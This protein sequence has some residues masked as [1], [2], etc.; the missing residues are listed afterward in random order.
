MDQPADNHLSGNAIGIPLATPFALD[1][2]RGKLVALC[3]VF[4]LLH[5]RYTKRTSRTDEPT[6]YQEDESGKNDSSESTPLFLAKGFGKNCNGSLV[7][8]TK[9]LGCPQDTT[10]LFDRWVRAMVPTEQVFSTFLYVPPDTI[11]YGIRF[12]LLR[13]AGKLPVIWTGNP[14]G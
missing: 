5:P 1:L 13:A 10:W 4:P 11:L 12:A 8:H 2:I 6:Q 9:H 3:D 14:L 7:V